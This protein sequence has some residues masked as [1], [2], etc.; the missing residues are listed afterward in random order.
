MGDLDFFVGMKI[1]MDLDCCISH[2]Q[3]KQKVLERF[4][5]ESSRS[6][7][8]LMEKQTVHEQHPDEPE[9]IQHEFKEAIVS[10]QYAATIS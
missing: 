1:K 9:V 5:V 7:A 6:V 2:R 4:R 8:T 10:L 3:D